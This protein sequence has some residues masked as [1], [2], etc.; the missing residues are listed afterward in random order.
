MTEFWFIVALLLL[1]GVMILLPPL[2]R[3]RIRVGEDLDARNVQI[4]RERLAELEAA[5][6][7]DSL[8]GAEF[9]QAKAELEGNL[10]DD[11]RE[12]SVANDDSPARIG[13]VVLLLV[14]P[15]GAVL[16]YGKL[17]SP[18]MIDRV[19]SVPE[20]GAATVAADQGHADQQASMDELLIRL[21]EKLKKDPENVE[22]WFILGR[23]YMSQN[24]YS[25]AIRA[26]EE[27]YKRA[28]DNA[29]VLV[30]LADALA[31]SSGGR[32]TG[33]AEELLL[34]SVELDPGSATAL[35]LLGMARQEQARYTEAIGYWQRAIPLL[36]DDANA[37]AQ[38]G[39]MIDQAKSM[40]GVA[41]AEPTV[42]A[43]LQTPTAAAAGITLTVRLDDALADKVSPGDTL[44][45]LAKAV[46]GPPMP[47]AAIKRQAG[48]LPLQVTLTDE[49]AMMP[50][51]KLSNFDRVIV[52]ARLTKG[53]NPMAQ[54]GDLQSAPLETPTKTTAALELVI[55][56]LVP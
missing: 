49:M 6:L 15:L 4:A 54:R 52:Q 33:R 29:N 7:N 48:D 18:Q 40:G 26:L 22:G 19:A 14:I 37:V 56:R 39:A 38:L 53:G 21:E 1:P 3:P 23:S 10:L 43:P 36:R 32:I 5:Q 13:L 30:S 17:G 24:R 51:L 41:E 46:K 16:L 9:E 27:T 28:P 12:E 47:L 25:D 44:F 42:P 34:R 35:W 45:V 20:A 8:S 11:L 31:M 55:D 50:Q 2:L